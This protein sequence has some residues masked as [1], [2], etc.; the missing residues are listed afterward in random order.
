MFGLR[1][2]LD[3]VEMMLRESGPAAVIAS[4]DVIW[5]FCAFGTEESVARLRDALSRRLRI[6]RSAL[7]LRHVAEIPVSA[8]GKVDYREVERWIKG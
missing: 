4:D 1:I 5:G 2:N 7:D 8:S 3:E 6:H